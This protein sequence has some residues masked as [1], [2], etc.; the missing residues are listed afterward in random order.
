MQRK[1]YN[2]LVRDKIPEIIAQNGGNPTTVT[3][4]ESLYQSALSDKLHEEITELETATTKQDITAE[5]ADIVEVLEALALT[6]NV[7]F[8]QILKEKEEKREKR[9]GFTKRIFLEYVDEAE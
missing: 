1:Q 2:K 5:I 8:E 6:H 7:S 4:E 9:G 3:L